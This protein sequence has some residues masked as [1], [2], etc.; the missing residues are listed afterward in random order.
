MKK[1]EDI[2]KLDK[3]AWQ[4]YTNNPDDIFDKD[5]N[6]NKIFK[7]K[8]L[9]YDLH[10]YTL[11]E[12]NNKIEELIIKCYKEKY[13]EILLITGKGI[14]SNSD[15][16]VF[17]SKNLSKLRFSIPEFIQSNSS[18]QNKIN[19]IKTAELKDGGEGALIIKIRKL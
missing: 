2:S 15:E 12:A 18:L 3:K 14:H 5:L 1:K 10:G 16:D 11:L 19:S 6:N 4:E 8:R 9:K 17:V 7:N 13:S